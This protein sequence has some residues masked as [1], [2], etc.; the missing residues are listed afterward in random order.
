[1]LDQETVAHIPNESSATNFFENA[2]ASI[3]RAH[4]RLPFI[5]KLVRTESE[6]WKAVQI[7]H[8]AYSRHVPVFAQSLS[9]PES[10][11][12]E[13]G[14][15]VLLA[16]SKV[17]GSPLGTMRI[18]TNRFKPLSLEQSIELPDHMLG[19]PLAEATRL[20][21]TEERIGRVVK[22]ILFKAFHQYCAQIGVEWMV[23]AG[24]FPID[25]QYE[26]LLFS[27]LYENLGYVP[28]VHA[29]NI[30]HRIMSLHVASVEERWDAVNHPLFN[31]FFRTIHEDIDVGPSMAR[32]V[33]EPQ[34]KI[35]FL[36][37]VMNK[38]SVKN[39]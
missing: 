12:L 28:L 6:L 1:M 33:P 4:E 32:F 15:V 3:Q 35:P 22:T 36:P 14:V 2:P 18:Q 21:I 13:N 23:V 37:L 5:V 8:S 16:E 30:P 25:K 20:G 34:N 24:R 38:V 39:L 27:E 31:L 9:I 11:D 29:G 17:D 19:R 7:R 10:N 26:R